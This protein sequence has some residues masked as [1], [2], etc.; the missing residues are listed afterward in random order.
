MHFWLYLIFL[1]LIYMD[2]QVAWTLGTCLLSSP[3]HSQCTT[4]WISG[5]TF[6][7]VNVISRLHT[8]TLKDLIAR[9]LWAIAAKLLK[10][11]N[12]KQAMLSGISAVGLGC[13]GRNIDVM[14][15]VWRNQKGPSFKV[16]SNCRKIWL[17]KR[18]NRTVESKQGRRG[19]NALISQQAG[20]FTHIDLPSSGLQHPA[21]Y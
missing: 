11:E 14:F 9:N 12:S 8:T 15:S 19:I 20:G 4:G 18:H 2:Q 6:I 21:T 5:W 1:S 17:F 10:L 16:V 13:N 3:L 7:S